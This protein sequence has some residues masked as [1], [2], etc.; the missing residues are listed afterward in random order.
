[1]AEW[2][3]CA[4]GVPNLGLF[5]DPVLLADLA[6]AEEEHGWDGFFLWDHLVWRDRAW[7]AADPV[8]VMSAVAA[9]TA[10]TGLTAAANVSRPPGTP[11]VPAG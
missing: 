1:M 8:V 9:R 11:G 7:P 10:A 6:A 3:R 4:V 2:P 5:A